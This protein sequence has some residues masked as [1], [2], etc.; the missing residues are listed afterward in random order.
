MKKLFCVFLAALLLAGCAPA[1]EAPVETTAAAVSTKAPDITVYDLAGNA[2]RLS[3]FAGKPVILNF[4]ASWCGPCKR[5]MPD[6]QAAYETYGSDIHF[7]IVNLTDG[8]QET[9]ESASG[10]IT[11]SGYTFPVYYDLDMDGAYSYGV[12]AIPMTLFLDAERN[13]VAYANTML[14]ADTLQKG[15][16][17][18][19]N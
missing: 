10:F 6:F 9:V 15:I 14:T 16:D 1:A 19:L 7:V 8:T 13:P 11:A 12:N 17:M 2:V 4:W 18:L 3:D 5:E